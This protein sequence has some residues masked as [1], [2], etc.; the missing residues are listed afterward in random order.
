MI[1]WAENLG[2]RKAPDDK[3]IFDPVGRYM[4]AKHGW[5]RYRFS[6]TDC[7]TIADILEKDAGATVDPADR[8]ASV[9]GVLL[10]AMTATPT[11][12]KMLCE[13]AGVSYNGHAKGE[14]SALVKRC[15]C[16]VTRGPRGGY[17]RQQ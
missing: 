6:H 7:G 13:K 16:S 4:I 14:L 11:R 5:N 9:Q 1:Y 17:A 2:I 3:M 8:T 12:A 15:A 10:S